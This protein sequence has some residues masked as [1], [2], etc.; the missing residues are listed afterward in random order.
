MMPQAA[1]IAASMPSALA[2]QWLVVQ[3]GANAGNA[4]KM[5]KKVNQVG[6]WHHSALGS[7]LE[8]WPFLEVDFMHLYVI[9]HSFVWLGVHARTPAPQSTALPRPAAGS[10]FR[11]QKATRTKRSQIK[12]ITEMP[13]STGSTETNKPVDRGIGSFGWFLR[14]G[15]LNGIGFWKIDPILDRFQIFP[16]VGKWMKIDLDRHWSKQPADKDDKPTIPS[17]IFTKPTISFHQ[18]PDK[19]KQ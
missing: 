12:K 9:L 10:Y 5:V 11:A 3:N 19:A 1:Q 2:S 16:K 15:S 6:S 13:R 7:G 18:A 4:T 8:V 17:T 14:S